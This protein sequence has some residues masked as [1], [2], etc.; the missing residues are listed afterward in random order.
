VSPELGG[1]EAALRAERAAALATVRDLDRVIAGVV[2]AT[3]GAN[4]D[5][6]HD[7]E[8]ATIAFERAQ[9]SAV[10]DRQLARVREVDEALARVA[11]GTFGTCARCGGP[12]APGRLLARPTA[13][14]CITCAALGR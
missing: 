8:G 3:E 5:D 7:P 10:R 14:L 12:I 9:A 2:E 4:T 1:V 11:D 13:T 6:E